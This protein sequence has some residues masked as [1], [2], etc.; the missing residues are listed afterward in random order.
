MVTMVTVVT[1]ITTVTIVTIVTM[2][3]I[4]TIVTRNCKCTSY[5]CV[6]ENPVRWFFMKDA[7]CK[8]L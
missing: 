8:D 4:V 1:I 7:V 2:V 6:E 5:L 3:T